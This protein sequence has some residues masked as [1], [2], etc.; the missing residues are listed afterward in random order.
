MASITTQSNGRRVVQFVGS[1]GKRRSVR[2]GK[3]SLR[4]AESIR[5]RVE[6]LVEAKLLGRSLDADTAGW[7]ASLDALMAR[8][9]A[10]VGLIESPQA[11]PVAT[12]GAFLTEHV[13]RR[14]DVKPATKEVWSQVTRNLVAFFGTDRDMARITEADADDFKMYLIAEKLATTPRGVIQGSRRRP[15]AVRAPRRHRAPA[16]SLPARVAHDHR[17]VQIRR[18]ESA[19]RSAKR[20]MGQ[21]ELGD[22][23][24]RCREPENGTSR[25][26]KSDCSDLRQA[27]ID[28]G[29]GL[30]RR[31][32]WR[33]VRGAQ[34]L[35]PSSPWPVRLAQLQHA[36]ATGAAGEEGRA[37]TV[38]RD[39]SQPAIVRRDRHDDPAPVAR[40]RA[41]AWTHPDDCPQA[42]LAGNGRRLH[43][44][45]GHGRIRG[46]A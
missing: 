31:R 4:S 33:G 35:P 36:D 25:E 7:V 13:S 29:G 19:F 34:P 21:R 22:R 27:Q 40:S 3:V 23:T 16:C 38:G 26:G 41:V 6:Q 14:I 18:A 9:L 32:G 11:K 42:L 10:A 44:S 20:K 1:D 8:R 28:L 2:L 17:L 15:Q 24:A 39:V 46:G 45:R 5:Y 12:L 43:Q 37:G 30:R